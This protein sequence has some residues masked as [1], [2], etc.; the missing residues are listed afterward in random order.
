MAQIKLEIGAIDEW[1]QEVK[2]IQRLTKELSLRF[3][4]L[5]AITLELE[6]K[7]NQAPENADT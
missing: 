1:E 2:E 7:V 5:R 4:N 6:A 3:S